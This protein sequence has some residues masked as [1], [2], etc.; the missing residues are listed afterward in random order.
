MQADRKRRRSL[1]SGVR[2]YRPLFALAV[3]KALLSQAGMA[4][5]RSVKARRVD[6]VGESV[7]RERNR[8]GSRVGAGRLLH[9]VRAFPLDLV[10]EVK[11]PLVEV[12]NAD[13]AVFS[14]ACV[15]LAGG[16]GGDGVE[17]AE[18][19]TDTADLVLENLVVESGLELALA[20]GGR[21]DVHGGLATTEDD[22]I[23]LG[24]D[25]GAVE[26]RVGGVGLHDREVASIDE[27][28][29]M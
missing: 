11:V 19:A 3:D 9:P 22:E 1:P 18:V 10:H 8:S 20:G 24:R 23:L 7:E 26:G 12:V 29:I 21:G 15:A 4:I 6:R 2:P 17:R 27:L 28:F 13:V 5:Y 14:A 25:G 16:V